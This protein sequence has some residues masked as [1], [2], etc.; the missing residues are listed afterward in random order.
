MDRIPGV[1]YGPDGQPVSGPG[2]ARIVK[3]DA[4]LTYTAPGQ[5][6]SVDPQK[7]L[8]AM[9][10]RR[11]DGASHQAI[12]AEFDLIGEARS[13]FVLERALNVGEKLLNE[14]IARGEQPAET[15]GLAVEF[16]DEDDDE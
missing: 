8:M 16:L 4:G 10:R 13:P 9:A 14:A 6:L 11:R 3:T 7:I 2:L 12:I 15:H 5:Q 1:I